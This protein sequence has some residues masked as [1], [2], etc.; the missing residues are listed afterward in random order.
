[1]RVISFGLWGNSP[2][3]VEGAEANVILAR[4]FYPDWK[5]WFFCDQTVPT[6]TINLLSSQPDC[7]VILHDSTV[8]RQHRLF[9]RFWAAE[10]SEVDTMIIRDTDSRIG[11]REQLAVMDWLSKGKSFHIMRDNPAHGVPICGGMW[12]C[13]TDKIRNIRSLIDRYYD[14]GRHHT[15]LC[16]VDQDFLRH[17]IWPVAQQDCTQHDEFFVKSSFPHTT[18]QERYYVGRVFSPEEHDYKQFT[19]LLSR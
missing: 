1:M 4:R 16:G 2:R 18:R 15:V 17:T 7:K 13:K 8:E 19:P 6:E 5:Y 3:Y 14:E 12:G 9:W 11:Q 10:Y